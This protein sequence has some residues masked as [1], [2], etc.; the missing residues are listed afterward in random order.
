[1]TNLGSAVRINGTLKNASEMEW[2]YDKDDDTPMLVETAM[3]VGGTRRS[4]R[5]SRPSTRLVDPDN[6]MNDHTLL[7]PTRPVTQKRKAAPAALV[8]QVVRRRVIDSED[9]GQ[10][11]TD[12][13]ADD[14]EVVESGTEAMTAEFEVLQE[15]AD[16]DHAVRVSISSMIVLLI[17]LHTCRQFE[18]EIFKIPLLTFAPSSEQKR[19]MLT[20]ITARFKMDIGAK[21]VC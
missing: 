12:D 8:H 20:L 3:E 18:V 7:A 13:D 19:S 1:M 17:H 11:P 9:E 6:A 2:H 5:S 21:S 14:T 10:A 16:V 15:M 4:G